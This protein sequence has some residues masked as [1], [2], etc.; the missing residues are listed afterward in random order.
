[1]KRS[2][3]A[4]AAGAAGIYLLRLDSAAGL[5]VDDAWYAVLAKALS[6]GDGFRLI[7]SATV[8]IVP[9]VPPGY[10]LLLAPLYFLSPQF[11]ANVW[12]L[13]LVSIAAMMGVGAV[14]FDYLVGT[15]RVETA[16]AALIA[17]ATVL[18]PAFVFLATSTL[19]AEC[20]FTLGQV[21]TILWIEKTLDAAPSDRQRHAIV[22]GILA[23][24][25]MLMRTAGAAAVL[26]CGLYLLYRRA[27]RPLAAF[28]LTT[29]LCLTPWM[30][31]S[32][33]NAPTSA[34]IAEH[35][36]TIAYPYSELLMLNRP[37]DPSVG[38]ADAA[39]FVARLGRNAV[40]VFGRDLG[41]I[42][43]PIAFRGASESGEE[44][45]SLGGN[46]G[47]MGSSMGS[48]RETVAITLVLSAIAVIGFITIVMRGATAAE[49]ATVVTVLVVLSVPTRTFRYLVPLT[50]YLLLYFFTGLGRLV[51][52]PQVAKLALLVVLAFHVLDHAQYIRARVAGEPL[53]WLED[54]KAATELTA[55]MNTNLPPAAVASTNPGF[56]YLTTGRKTVATDDFT[57]GWQ[58]WKASGVR[59]MVAL[60]P[61]GFPQKNLGYRVVYESKARHYWVVDIEGP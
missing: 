61:L 19:M 60:R 15:R 45:V 50:P 28:A 58:R 9:T 55:W 27:T 48:G 7:S 5:I 34:E 4:V 23:G 46:T 56:V 13:K 49:F 8:P 17:G 6:Q 53:D 29:I 38:R 1:M 32:V 57:R 41:G 18:T 35:G 39:G 11:P 43:L 36:G 47:F 52:N 31:Y 3:L 12:L 26:G 33:K 16:T 44:V 21:L 14:V 54:F 2:Y 51:K 30:I 37:G 25:T 42:V 20:V 40:N 59:Y 24:A 10:P 22:A